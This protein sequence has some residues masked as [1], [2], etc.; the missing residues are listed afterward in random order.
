MDGCDDTDDPVDDVA[1]LVLGGLGTE[2]GEADIVGVAVDVLARGRG[3]RWAM[4][5]I[6]L[7]LLA[8]AVATEQRNQVYGSAISFWEDT[9]EKS[10]RK[11]RVANNLGFAYQQAGRIEE[12]KLAYRQAIELDPDYW[13][14]RINLDALES[15][16]P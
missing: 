2:V 13:R 16:R 10:S 15:A 8:L 3:R 11:A 1:A 14:A 5:A 12:A 6:G 9:L 4:A 7:V